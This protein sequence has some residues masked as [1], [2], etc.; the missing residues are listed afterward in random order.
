[1][2]LQIVDARPCNANEIAG[3]VGQWNVLAI[4]GGRLLRIKNEQGE[5]VGLRLPV[6]GTRR[7]DIVLN[8]DDTYIVRRIRTVVRGANRGDEVV[9]FEQSNVYCDEVGE[10]A[11]SASCWK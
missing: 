4:S 1:M 5:T 11:Y 2:N 3:Q 7:V 6:N 9:E 8:W 10:V